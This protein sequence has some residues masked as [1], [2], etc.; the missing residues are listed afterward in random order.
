[1]SFW[2]NEIKNL[3]GNVEYFIE[4]GT[5]LVANAMDFYSK[6]YSIK[7][8]DGI[9]IATLWGSVF[10]ITGNSRGSNFPFEI[11]KSSKVGQNV[12]INMF[13]GYTC[14][15]SDVFNSSVDN[16]LS[17][18]DII[19][20]KN[21]GSYSLVF[22]PPFILPNCPVYMFYDETVMVIKRSENFDDIFGTYFFD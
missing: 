16:E 20:F 12:F 21:V 13:V 5:A 8:V 19:V 22:K 7:N 17:I 14:I 6:I 18:N 3:L 15:E 11:I 10:N 9:G 2:L 4:P 1:M